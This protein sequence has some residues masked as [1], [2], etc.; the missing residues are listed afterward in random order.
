M[1]NSFIKYV[2]KNFGNPTGTGGKISTHI[3]NIINQ[4]QYN[5]VLKNI[6]L[7]PHTSVLDIGFG[8][9]YVIRKILR[10]HIPV[11]M[12]GIEISNDMLKSVSLKN[13]Q[14]IITGT[15]QLLLEDIG[16]T[17]FAQ[18]TFDTVYTVNTIY[19]WNDLEK[20]FSEIKRILK[21]GG[22]FLNVLY[23]KEYL[24]KI[25]YTKYGFKKYTIEEIET[26]T[27]NSGMQISEIIEIKKKKSYCIIAE[28]IK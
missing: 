14:H 26:S 21:P 6:K 15:V 18:N 4:K 8:N 7:E 9:G 12:Y 23:T 19:F 3:M 27:K 5:A 10:Q 11:K 2:G 28:N 20:G 22:I 17:S 1:L 16:K 25:M 24:N 13:R